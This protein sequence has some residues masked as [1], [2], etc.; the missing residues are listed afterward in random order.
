MARSILQFQMNQ[1][2]NN[3][4]MRNYWK[5]FDYEISIFLTGVV[6]GEIIV[7]IIL[8]INL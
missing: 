4:A 1:K 7:G 3:K 6:V 5:E 8:I 2:S